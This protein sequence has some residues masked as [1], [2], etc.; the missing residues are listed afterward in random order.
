MLKD[1][2]LVR[3]L[4]ACE[5]MGNATTVC[6]DKTGTL[7]QNKMAVVAGTLGSSFRFSKDSP[8]PDLVDLHHLARR[9]PVPVRHLVQQ[10]I[11]VNTTAFESIAVNGEPALLGSKTETAL[12]QFSQQWLHA[13]AFEKA[14]ARYPAERVYPFTSATKAMATVVR[15]EIAGR[16]VYRMH[17][18]GASEMLVCRST[19][20]VSMHAPQYNEK[21]SDVETRAMTEKNRMRMRKIIQSYATRCLRT[22]ALAYKDFDQLPDAD[23]LEVLLSQ[24]GLTL[25]GVIGIE[26]PLRPNARKAVQACQRAGVCV[27]MVTGDN[28]LTAKSIA[29]Q[30]G[31]Y[32]VG[33]QALDGPSY[34]RLTTPERHALLPSLKILARSTPD[35]KRL[36]VEDLRQC[37]EI[38][39]VTGDGT[40]DGPALTAAD[41]GFAMGIAGT[42]V[43]KEASHIILM[44]DNF[45][46]IVKAISWGR[47]VNDSVKKFLQFQL[48]VN[49]TA[50]V[51]TLVSAMASD[52]QTSVLTAVQ[53]LWVNL[54]MDTFG[55]LA[56]ATD[57]P[58]P[59]MLDRR[60]EPRTAP[61]ISSRMWK[62]II[63]QAVY[64]IL[65]ILALLYTNVLGMP[66]TT[67]QTMVFTTFVF[68]QIFN[69]IK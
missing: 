53:L 44:D 9:L 35:D 28:M 26:D 13:E 65:V 68:C 33:D 20:L 32:T 10:A 22:L 47:C 36:L 1:N 40:N 11:A 41:V 7:T 18:K 19:A 63:G 64:Q 59:D 8:Q 12:I 37:G 49:I 39:A 61:L 43:A 23:D 51:L 2:N 17:V 56:L 21:T 52:D 24:G 16:T 34:R 66:D 69:E 46:S 55:A 60:P 67:L 58:S 6:S 5:T 14:R 3:V 50:V 48:T 42:E 4:S 31:M 45:G 15:L 62:M 25:V 27:R 54:I 30:C 38:V 57:P 29:R